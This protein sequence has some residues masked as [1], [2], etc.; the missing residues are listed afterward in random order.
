ME[1]LIAALRLSSL[2]FLAIFG[3]VAVIWIFDEIYKHFVENKF[4]RQLLKTMLLTFITIT[5]LCYIA[6][7]MNWRR[8]T[9]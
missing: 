9:C 3:S 4:F 1:N 5:F 2:L 8:I 6:I 7:L